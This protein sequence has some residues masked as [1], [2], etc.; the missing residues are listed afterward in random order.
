MLSTICR[1]VGHMLIFQF[2][3]SS[4]CITH[5]LY[6]SSFT[7]WTLCGCCRM[8]GNFGCLPLHVCTP[9]SIKIPHSYVSR[10]SNNVVLERAG[11]RHLSSVLL[12]RQAQLYLQICAL[13]EPSVLRQLTLEPGSTRP[14][15][16]HGARCR[17][18]PKQ[19]WPSCVAALL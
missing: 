6:R 19:Q 9:D 18:R 4:N 2:A 12:Q 1:N 10:I 17:G 15:V 3:A 11:E 7:V 8:A 5:V 13:P 14:R 16:W